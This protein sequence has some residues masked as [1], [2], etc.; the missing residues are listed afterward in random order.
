MDEL[1][2][3]KELMDRRQE[4]FK[5]EGEP[6]VSKYHKRPRNEEFYYIDDTEEEEKGKAKRVGLRTL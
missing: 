5:N 6:L 4:R 2:L 1:L 3:F